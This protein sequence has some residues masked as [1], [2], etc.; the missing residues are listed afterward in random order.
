MFLNSKKIQ[1]Y[2]HR[3]QESFLEE[4]EENKKMLDIYLRYVEGDASDEDIDYANNQLKQNLKSLGLGVLVVLPFSPITIPYI[5]KK[6]QEFNIDIIPNWYK[7][8]SRDEDS[9]K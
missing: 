1:L 4:N 6:T 8:L 2:L 7:A 3:L 9:L 5:L